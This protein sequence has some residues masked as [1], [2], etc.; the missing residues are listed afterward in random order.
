M[1]PVDIQITYDFI[2]PWCWI[3]HRNL[4]AAIANMAPEA[5]PAISFLPYELNPGMPVEGADRKAYRT[6]KFGSWAR[7]QAM[8]AEV[9]MVGRRAG[10]D[11]HYE[12][13]SVTPNTRLAHRLM[14]FA[15]QTGDAA[16]ADALF[17]A[18]FAAYFARGEHIGLIDVL[19]QLAVSAGFDAQAVRA[20]LS[21]TDGEAEVAAA[22]ALAQREGVRSVPA[23]RIGRTAIGGAQPPSFLE[24]AL[25][26]AVGE[27]L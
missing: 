24:Q 6:A 27:A 4:K 15:Q 8:D 14:A 3:G 23:I 9:A 2:C 7:S 17:E 22:E 26:A 12:R 19:V 10:L 16:K 21:G 18:V 5:A 13:I 20:Y 11:F 25:G 1:K